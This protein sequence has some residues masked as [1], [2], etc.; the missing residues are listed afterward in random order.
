METIIRDRLS[1]AAL[2]EPNDALWSD[3]KATDGFLDPLFERFYK[4][5]SLPPDLMRKTNYHVLA[6]YVQKD[7]IDPEITEKL[8]AIVEV[9]QQAKPCQDPQ[10]E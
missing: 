2:R 10:D 1:P 8:D 3:V 7:N 4:E 9:A 6:K 5:V